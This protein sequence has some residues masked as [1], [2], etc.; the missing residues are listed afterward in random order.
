M[1]TAQNSS[2]QDSQII[3]GTQNISSSASTTNNHHNN[4]NNHIDNYYN[5]PSSPSSSPSSPSTTIVPFSATNP[6]TLSTN[7][8]NDCS[9]C[10]QVR[11]NSSKKPKTCDKRFSPYN[12][13]VVSNSVRISSRSSTIEDESMDQSYNQNTGSPTI[14]NKTTQQTTTTTPTT[15][16]GE[17]HEEK[18]KESNLP[19]S[20]CYEVKNKT[21]KIKCLVAEDNDLNQKIV[22]AFL[23][24]LGFESEY[25]ENGLEAYQKAE[26]VKYDI[27]LMDIMMPIMDGLQ[28]TK[29]IRESGM[30]Q[31]T[32]IIAVTAMGQTEAYF[33]AHGLDDFLAKPFTREKHLKII[34][35]H[36]S[37]LEGSF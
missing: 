2:R 28:S 10:F 14:E 27:I 32:L 36:K 29:L 4:S 17:Q 12:T 24:R 5:S 25:V 21:Q 35:K 16:R 22:K 13:R 1:T 8:Q 7:Y 18:N 9:S 11:L 19:A 23:D 34:D 20:P 6:E 15:N 37:K 31:N 30:N 26:I 3:N 33:K